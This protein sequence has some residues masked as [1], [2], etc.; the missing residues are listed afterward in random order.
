MTE[1]LLAML[2]PLQVATTILG[3][4]KLLL[5]SLP[6]RM[7]TSHHAMMIF[8]ADVSEQP[9]ERIV[10]TTTPQ[11]LLLNAAA[12]GSHYKG[13][14]FLAKSKCNEVWKV[15]ATELPLVAQCQQQT[16]PQPPAK[17][18]KDSIAG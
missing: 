5:V 6:C 1:A 15:I 9:Q 18:M 16:T 10:M 3:G 8:K 17:R 4:S 12:M 7:L 11:S 14:A 2:Q 13:L